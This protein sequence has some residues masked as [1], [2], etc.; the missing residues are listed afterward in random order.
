[1]SS[2]DFPQVATPSSEEPLLSPEASPFWPIVLTLGEI[3][4]RVERRQTEEHAGP[5]VV[6]ASR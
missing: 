6:G 5:V 4:E 3:A 2:P 1:M